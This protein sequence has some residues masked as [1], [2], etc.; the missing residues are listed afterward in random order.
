MVAPYMPEDTLSVPPFHGCPSASALQSGERF[1]SRGEAAMH[2]S[3]ADHLTS[4]EV[5]FAATEV[6]VEMF[7][8]TILHPYIAVQYKIEGLL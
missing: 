3:S 8:N 7:E 6:T 4:Q 2:A 5:D 1:G